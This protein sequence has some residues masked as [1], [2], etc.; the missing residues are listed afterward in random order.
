VEANDGSK[1]SHEI[2]NVHAQTW[3]VTWPCDSTR[4]W[5]FFRM[6]SATKILL[7]MQE[8]LPII[9]ASIAFA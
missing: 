4:A 1:V 9:E 5:G 7:K 2:C 8:E 6:S 3:S